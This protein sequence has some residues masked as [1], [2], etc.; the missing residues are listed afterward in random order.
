MTWL[1]RSIYQAVLGIT[2]LATTG[3]SLASDS[4]QPNFLVILAD[5]LGFSDFGCYGGEI[6]TPNIDALAAGGL[7]YSQFYNTARCWPTRAALLTGYYPQQMGRDALPV[8]AGQKKP[9]PFNQARP[10]WARLL[11]DLLQPLGYRCYHSGK[12]H[13][14]GKPLNH[15][16]HHSYEL[17]TPRGYFASDLHTLD[18]E[19]HPDASEDFYVTTA[20]A[21]HAIEFLQQHEKQSPDQP[22]FEYIAFTAPHFPLHAPQADINKYVGR[23]DRGWDEVRQRRWQKLN[24]L[25]P[26]AGELSALEPNIG[27]PY[28]WTFEKAADIL[29]PGEV[30]AEVAWD[31]LNDVQKKFQA[32][33]MAIHAA[34]IDRMDREIGRIVAQLRDSGKLDN[35]VIMILSDNGASAEIMVRGDGHDPT[36]PLGSAATYLCLGAGWSSAANT[37]FRRHKTW[38]HEGGIAT[39]MVVHWPDGIS[40]RG[41]W[42]TAAGHVIDIAPTMVELA[43]GFWPI[44]SKGINVPPTPGRSI[45]STFRKDTLLNRKAIWWLHEDNRAIRMGNWKLVAAKQEPWELYDLSQDRAETNNLATKHPRRAKQLAQKWQAMTEEFLQLRDSGYVY[46]T[47]E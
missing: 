11:P 12:W 2:F 47:A 43:G 1:T 19:K 18:G 38:V 26:F 29:G 3:P 44:K 34:M 6:R 45:A 36:A 37:P 15:G 13:V 23:Y 28:P 10:Q 7:R 32:M 42:R 30:N 46:Q 33:K 17:R 39:P 4:L 16:F 8:K 22:F 20:V 31:S 25:H 24:Q 35:T 14:D 21:D 5:D 27:T 9:R 40:A 41:E